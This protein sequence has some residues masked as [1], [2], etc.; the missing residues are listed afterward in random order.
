MT[1]VVIGDFRAQLLFGED[2]ILVAAKSLVGCA[3]VLE[4]P[5][6]RVTYH[7]LMFDDPVAVS[8]SMKL[9]LLEWHKQEHQADFEA[10]VS[11]IS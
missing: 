9:L 3:G 5:V 11:A 6:A 10:A 4:Q 7:H 8:M 2:E 1:A